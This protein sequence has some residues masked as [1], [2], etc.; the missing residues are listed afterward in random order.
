MEKKMTDNR[1]LREKL[2]SILES[3]DIP[4]WEWDIKKNIV[5]F[6]DL[7]VTMLGYKVED[8]KNAGYQAFTSLI[9][10][11]DHERSMDAMRDHL[12]GKAQIY[13]IDYRIKDVS[14]KYRWYLDRGAVIERDST[15]APLI[16]R[17]IVLD[18]GEYIK[19]ETYI[20][21]V[22][23][24]MHESKS[25]MNDLKSGMITV[26][27]NCTKYQISAQKWISIDETFARNAAVDVSHT[28]CPECL[29]LLYPEIAK[30]VLARVVE[31][32]TKKG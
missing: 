10:P 1:Q 8:F 3:S 23:K 2:N 12:C 18:M 4:W 9:H 7:K 14:G 24:I 22:M 28:L 6:N 26:C 5:T 27:C 13:Q 16:L 17:G 32:Q 20:E 25:A 11:E 30:K 21:T 15:G 19:E 31:N 29:T